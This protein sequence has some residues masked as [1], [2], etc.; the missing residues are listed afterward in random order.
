MDEL[1]LRKVIAENLVYYRREKG[2]TQA[3]LAETLNYSDKSVSKWE[4]GEGVPDITVLCRLAEY[5]GITVNDLLLTPEAR[6]QAA[7]AAQAAE[8]TNGEEAEATDEAP[9]EASKKKR[10][11]RTRILVPVL[12]IGLVWL[13]AMVTF[14][15]M[16]VLCP[17]FAYGWLIFLYAIPVSFIVATVFAC[18][19]WKQIVRFIC[20]SGIVWSVSFSVALSIVVPNIWLIY[21]VAGVLQ[22]LTVLW[23]IQFKK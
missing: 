5:Y 16:E 18:I 13:V 2:L 10:S 19:W 1:T 23:F 8:A 11:L 22:I 14:F 4:R 15:F 21:A 9:A 17:G 6:Q 20:V 3:A 12:S 7:E